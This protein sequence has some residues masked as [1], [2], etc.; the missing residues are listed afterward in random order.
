M[1]MTQG[2]GHKKPTASIETVTPDYALLILE[3]KLRLNRTISERTV[4]AYAEMMSRN[5]QW[6]V[7]GQGLTFDWDGFLIDGQHRLWA[8]VRHDKPVD[9]LVVRNAD[10]N[11]IGAIDKG[12]SRKLADELRMLRGERNH[13]H[14]AAYVNMCAWLL[15]GDAVVIKTVDVFDQWL[16]P[17]EPGVRWALAHLTSKGGAVDCKPGYVAGPLAFAYKTDPAKIEQFGVQLLSGVGLQATDPS[18]V[19]G[20]YLRRREI[21]GK[22]QVA[23]AA[24]HK[25]I[26]ARKVLRMAMLH[27]Q[28]KTQ[29]K[30][31]DTNLGVEFFRKAYDTRA[32]KLLVKPWQNVPSVEEIRGDATVHQEA[33][34]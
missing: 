8:V 13:L 32:V 12:R 2:N 21:R 4:N 5:G 10:P 18:Y 33:S 19:L 29:A 23:T 7:T 3:T 1:L 9:M 31:E 34:L 30:I 14:L 22:G 25:Q 6:F 20:G 17:V 27:V 24:D 28:G 16:R 26:V 11:S 15:T